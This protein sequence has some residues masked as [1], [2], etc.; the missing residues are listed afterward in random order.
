[1]PSF[2]DEACSGPLTLSFDLSNNQKE[3][4]IKNNNPPAI[5]IAAAITS[6]VTMLKKRKLSPPTKPNITIN[7]GAMINILIILQRLQPTPL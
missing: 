1:M 2:G 4:F 3:N 5:Q 7:I 6:A